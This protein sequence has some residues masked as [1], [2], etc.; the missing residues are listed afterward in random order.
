[1]ENVNCYIENDSSTEKIN[2]FNRKYL[3]RIYLYDN[4]EQ[5]VTKSFKYNVGDKFVV[6]CKR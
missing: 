1:M 2:F 3:T 5:K 6:T 4:K